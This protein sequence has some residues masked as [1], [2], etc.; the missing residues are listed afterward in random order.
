MNWE[1]TPTQIRALQRTEFEPRKYSCIVSTKGS[2]YTCECVL[3]G[4]LFTTYKSR[5]ELGR[6]KFCSK[7]CSR[8]NDIHTL[9]TTG[10]GT[11]FLTGTKPCNTKGFR[12]TCARG[13]GHRYKQLHL[14]T[15][16]MADKN[17]YVREHRFIMEQQIGRYLLKEEI[18]HHINGDTLDNRVEN[19]E[20]MD[21]KEHRR[22]H[23][24]DT[25]HKRWIT[26]NNTV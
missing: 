8:I 22:L 4:S 1:P 3:C 17:G 5:C 24:K 20:L 18:V 7:T 16:P 2:L 13:G 21:H 14:P 6:G 26:R 12:Y 19:L 10:F 15:H 11:R 25:L 23:L 9:T